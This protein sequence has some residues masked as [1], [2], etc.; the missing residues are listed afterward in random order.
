MKAGQ[1]ALG[2]ALHAQSGKRPGRGVHQPYDLLV[3]GAVVA[4]EDAGFD[5]LDSQD[6]QRGN[7][8]QGMLGMR[9]HFGAGIASQGLDQRFMASGEGSSAVLGRFFDRLGGCF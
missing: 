9:Q 5:V 3:V 1:L 8:H 4:V 6:R 7:V 2:F